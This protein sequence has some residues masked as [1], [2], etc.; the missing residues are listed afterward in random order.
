MVWFRKEKVPKKQPEKKKVKMPEGLWLKCEDCK[1]IIYRNVLELNYFVCPK[2]SYHFR[3]ST[4]KRLEYIFGE[5][6][7]KEF[8]ANLTSKDPLKFRDSK[9]YTQR[10]QSS[11]SK[12]GLNDAVINVE[13]KLGNYDIIVSIMD[14][15]FMGG[16]M[17]SV[18]GE[19]ITR[20]FEKAISDHKSIIVISCTG[21]AR[22]QEGMFSLMQM[23]KT[24][25]IVARFHELGYPYISI[26]TDPTT[27]GVLASF[28]MLGDIIIAEPH[29]LIGF[30]GRR[31]IKQTIN[32]DLPDDF[33]LSEFLVQHGQIDMIVKRTQLTSTLL[34]LLDL[35]APEPKKEVI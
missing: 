19:K 26:L 14:F 5:N 30:A 32:E 12:T 23:V 17:G 3:I 16:S 10:I 22:M 25:S 8:D 21:G 15:D 1:E 11:I 24:S 28:A 33:Q 20:A 6:G 9:K 35:L 27:A 34:N 13:G 4:A 18:V 29:A 31:V 2:C 7:Y